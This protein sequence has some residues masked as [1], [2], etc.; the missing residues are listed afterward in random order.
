MS[1]I[2]AIWLLTFLVY[3]A[4]TLSSCSTNSYKIWDA[5]LYHS[6][7]KVLHP[8]TPVLHPNCSWKHWKE[9]AVKWSLGGPHCDWLPGWCNPICCN[10]LSLT[11]QP[12]VH[13]LCYVVAYLFAGHFVQNDIVR[14]VSKA[15]LKC[16]KATTTGFPWPTS[17]P[18][19]QLR[20][21]VVLSPPYVLVLQPSLGTG[22]LK[23]VSW[24]F[25]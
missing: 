25:L 8:F 3:S 10:P 20:V 19:Q 4:N 24:Y 6:F 15:L 5:L 13:P 9:L 16:R 1:P 17:L 23:V 7:L 18:K 11:T 14:T 2:R 22:C 12:S 21:E